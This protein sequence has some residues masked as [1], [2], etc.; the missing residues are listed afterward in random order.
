MTT[1]AFD[2]LPPI[3]RELLPELDPTLWPPERHADCD[4]CTLISPARGPWAFSR[5]TRCCTAHPP[6]ANYLAGR[7]LRRGEPGRSLLLARMEDPDGVCAWGIDPPDWLDARY[8]AT[9]TEAFGRDVELRC[10]LYVGG[11]KTCGIWHDRSAI[12]RT[13]FCRHEDGLAGA[14][15]WSKIQQT[16]TDLEV[17]VAVW[18]VEQGDPPDDEAPAD[19]MAA[20]YERAAALVDAC[21]RADVEE[22]A[23]GPDLARRR[24]EVGKFVQ[25]RRARRRAMPARLIPSVTEMADVD[26]EVLLTGYSSFDAVRAPKQV[27]ELL[28]RLDG[29]TPWRDALAA[30]QAALTARGMDVAWLHEPLVLH[31]HR[32]G[33]LRDPDGGDDLPYDVELMEMNKWSTAGSRKAGEP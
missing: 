32:V 24:A 11:E 15:A 31:L 16:L 25:I 20:W 9:I 21:T 29:A 8:K 6:L 13:W 28:S 5:E 12:C 3:F 14:V 19:E 22:I 26:G 7:A 18:A 30:T 4:N 23:S 17:R 27:F 33:A 10:P 1:T 2:H